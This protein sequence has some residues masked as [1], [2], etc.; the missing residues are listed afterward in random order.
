MKIKLVQDSII[1]ISELKKSEFEEA[2]RFCKDALTLTVKDENTKK[3][4]PI[5]GI[6]YADE[7][8]VSQNG[9]VFDSTT[10]EGFMC[11][12]LVAAQGYDEHLDADAKIKAISE[13]FASLI[14]K[15]NDLEAQVKAALTDNAAKI[16][17]ARD[18][19]EVVNI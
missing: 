5:C 15:M 6:H 3:V 14:L 11:K 12:T 17:A 8:S 2:K 19:V 9:I 4:T 7:G 16:T 18:S 10:E 13:E 1:F